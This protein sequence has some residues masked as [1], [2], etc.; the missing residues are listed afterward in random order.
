MFFLSIFREVKLPMF[1]KCC[2]KGMLQRNIEHFL[3]KCI[4]KIRNFYNE[5]TKFLFYFQR[6]VFLNFVKIWT[7]VFT[8][9]FCLINL[10][11]KQ[12]TY[13]LRINVMIAFQVLLKSDSH[14]PKNCF[15]YFNESPLKWLKA[16]FI[17]S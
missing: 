11:R 1:P 12:W 17:S 13:V 14:L 4:W 15:I 6:S 5:I 8:F 3:K 10:W 16:L 7:P 2:I 9:Y